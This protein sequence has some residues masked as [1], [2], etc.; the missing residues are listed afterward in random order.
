MKSRI[1]EQSFAGF[2]PHFL[3]GGRIGTFFFLILG[4]VILLTSIVKP[5]A[6]GG[7]RI[8]VT[9]TV[10]PV[11]SAVSRPFQN[12]VEA[13]SSVSGMAELRAENAQL[14]A[15]NIR[16]REWY[17]TALMLQAEN[18][19]LQELLNLKVD[20]AHKFITAR[21]ISDFGNA[22]VKS[23]LVAAGKNEG[24]KKDHAVLASEGLVGRVIDTGKNSARVLL[25]TDLNSRVPVIIEGSSQKAIL[26]GTNDKMPVLKH[27]PP[28]S[29]VVKGAR[30]VTSGHGG[31]FPAG[32][33]V[34]R[35]LPG[36]DSQWNVELYANMN[37]VTHVRVVDTQSDP[38]LVRGDF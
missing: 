20:T 30:I 26:A 23:V 14:K 25:I 6:V 7:L 2:A 4:C 3:L 38:N 11:L 17:Q 12:M 29:G 1:K 8:G 5:S 27:L 37:Q 18:Q 33:A 15:E 35:V 34:G 31:K 19:S 21:V 13:F 36:I 10:S 24:V 9:D 22:Y 28:D 32:L 16:L